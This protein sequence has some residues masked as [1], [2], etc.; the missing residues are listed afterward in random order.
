MSFDETVVWVIAALIAG[1]VW[2]PAGLLASTHERFGR[3]TRAGLAPVAAPFLGCLLLLW[4]LIRYASFDVRE[5]RL[6][7]AFYVT[8][9][10][11]VVGLG[12]VALDRMGLSL[13]DDVIE[14][15]NPAACYAWSGALLGLVCAFGG[16][17]IGD[18]P[19]WWVVV[20]CSALSV[21]GLLL[22]W[23]LLDRLAHLGE[24]VTVER[25]VAAG[26]RAA[27]W[28]IGCGA[29]LGRAAAGD[30]TTAE[31]ALV[32]FLKHGAGALLL[33]LL[34][35]GGEVMVGPSSHPPRDVV[36]R[37]LVFSLAWIWLGLGYV[38]WVGSW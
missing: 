4:I 6:Y 26:L 16:A 2:L 28:F 21:G 18:G 29:I 15:G 32:D 13:R 11:A 22:G 31:A 3:G 12:S 37:G 5:D 36:T 27:G 8:L 35:L 7:L 38:E 9:G 17:N 33:T 30:W 20:Y 1:F 24:A 14:R 23:I 34:A 10:A 25:D 19:G